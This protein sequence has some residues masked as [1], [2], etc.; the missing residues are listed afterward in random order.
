[1]GDTF[2]LLGT[3]VRNRITNSPYLIQIPS[4]KNNG[5][6]IFQ[7]GYIRADEDVRR[8]FV[9]YTQENVARQAFKM[10]NH[11]YGW[12]DRLGGR[13]CSRFIMDLFASFGMVM[14]RNSKYQAMIGEDL[15]VDEDMRVREKL[16]ILDQA[17][18][19]TTL[20]RLP[21]HIMLYLGKH[22]GRHYAIHSL[23]SIQKADSTGPVLSKVGRVV[24]SDL[25]LGQF[26]PNGSL[27]ERISDVRSISG[28]T[29]LP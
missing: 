10:L 21:G 6:L 20:L 3:L 25:N 26:T 15:G 18:P 12:G 24:V 5:K 23:W 8:G 17:T 28:G 7:K 16:H 11:P 2:P 22:Q 4:R 1:M 13:D 19:M 14:P 29:R 9:S 27:L